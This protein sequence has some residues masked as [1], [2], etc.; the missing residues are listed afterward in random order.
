MKSFL[1]KLFGSKRNRLIAIVSLMVLL[2]VIA[3]VI[4]YTQSNIPA[5]IQNPF[6]QSDMV[7]RG[8]LSVSISGS[9]KLISENIVSLAFST[10][11]TVQILNVKVGQQVKKGEVLAGLEK[12]EQLILDVENKELALQAADKAIQDLK[13]NSETALAQALADQASAGETYESAQKDLITKGQPRCDKFVTEQYY[14]DYMYARHDYNLWHSY[15]IDGGT[16]YGTMYIQER[17]APYQKSMQINYANWKYC[18]GYTDLEKKETEATLALAESNL[19]KAKTTYK[20]LVKNNGIDPLEMAILQATKDDAEQQLSEAE[21]NLTDATLIA[22]FDGVITKV[23][24]I[25]GQTAENGEF[26]EMADLENEMIQTS[27]E[28]TDVQNFKAGCDAVVTFTTHKDQTFNGTVTRVDP[29]LVSGFDTQIAQGWVK[30]SD[31]LPE[32]IKRYSLGLDASV[33]ITCTQAKD[34]LLVPVGAIHHNGET[35][36]V[37][38]LDQNRTPTKR[39]VEIGQ[40]TTVYAEIR[41]GLQEG[42]IVVI[43]QES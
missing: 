11:G 9:G 23:N 33:E 41:S 17:M 7:R 35:S 30:L 21:K 39:D 32:N 4:V 12:T 38:V 36:Y 5:T 22:P 29:A 19:E 43:E 37:H 28:E 20:E 14:Y 2:G 6:A 3:L 40:T 8:D 1:S 26:I 25:V 15:L 31:P 10:E 13:D 24:G 27:I 18:E 42:E 34:V 16:G